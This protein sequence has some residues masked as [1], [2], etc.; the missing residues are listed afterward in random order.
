MVFTIAYSLSVESEVRFGARSNFVRG[1]SR[2]DMVRPYSNGSSCKEP[3]RT[4]VGQSF[5]KT[6][7]YPHH[8]YHYI[9]VS[10]S[11]YPDMLSNLLATI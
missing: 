11:T 10:Y 7:Y 8:R 3:L 4:F 9:S 2:L 6:I 1:I 5:N